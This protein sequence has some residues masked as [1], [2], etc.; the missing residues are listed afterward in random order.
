MKFF[1]NL[2]IYFLLKEMKFYSFQRSKSMEYNN[3]PESVF[4]L[5]QRAKRQ[6]ALIKKFLHTRHEYLDQRG[7]NS[8]AKATKELFSGVVA[9]GEAVAV[10]VADDDYSVN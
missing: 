3:K 9:S 2:K 7:K 8:P 1:S 6:K 5:K 4:S 10:G